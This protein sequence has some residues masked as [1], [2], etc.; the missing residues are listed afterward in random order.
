MK[1]DPIV[2]MNVP[3]SKKASDR[4]PLSYEALK[5]DIAALKKGVSYITKESIRSRVVSSFTHRTPA[6][7]GLTKEQYNEL[8]NELDKAVK[9][10]DAKTIDKAIRACDDLKSDKEK[11]LAEYKKAKA[12]YENVS[13]NAKTL[14]EFKAL[15]NTQEF[16]AFKEAERVCKLLGC[17]I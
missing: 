14:A 12:D 1:Y 5:S 4:D 9:G 7:G 17:V 6:S 15:S 2:C 3:E 8:L 11:A 10:K 13:K 16:K